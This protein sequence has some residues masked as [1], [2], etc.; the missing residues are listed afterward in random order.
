MGYFLKVVI[1][2]AG[3]LILFTYI[4]FQIPQQASLPP[5]EEKFDAAQIQSKNDL[6]QIGSKLFYG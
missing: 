1:F 2:V 6:V 5:G 3:F 4:A